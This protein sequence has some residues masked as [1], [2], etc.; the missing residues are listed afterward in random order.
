VEVLARA[1]CSQPDMR[2][3]SC[4]P[5]QK[6]YSP[7][8]LLATFKRHL[9][10]N[11]PKLNFNMIGF[12]QQCSLFV[13]EARKQTGRSTG[14][15][16]SE[17]SPHAVTNLILAQSANLLHVGKPVSHTLLPVI[18]K[19]L[20]DAIAGPRDAYSRDAW[21]RSSGHLSPNNKPNMPPKQ[22]PPTTDRLFNAFVHECL[23]RSRN[24]VPEDNKP[25]ATIFQLAGGPADRSPIIAMYK[26]LQR[27]E[28]TYKSNNSEK[29]LTKGIAALTEEMRAWAQAG[30]DDSAM[31][32][33]LVD[34]MAKSLVVNGDTGEGA[35][36]WLNTIVKDGFFVIDL[37]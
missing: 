27:W 18:W 13:E 17:F 22:D 23:S 4:K 26:K 15:D 6:A 33:G 20:G 21:E 10:K 35:R 9:I 31:P 16:M 19:A 1:D 3:K 8:S 12:S 36:Q 2:G 7:I 37:A 11:E 29:Q 25:N 34:I 28:R 5:Q 30:F 24:W 14:H 32:A